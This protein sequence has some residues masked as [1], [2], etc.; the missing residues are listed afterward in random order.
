MYKNQTIYLKHEKM[1]DL[2]K[3]QLNTEGTILNPN[4]Y[5]HFPVH[6][7]QKNDDQLV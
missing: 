3:I 2:S 7:Q 5:Q 4:N 1:A 6:N